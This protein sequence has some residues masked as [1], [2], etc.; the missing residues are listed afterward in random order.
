MTAVASE[1]QLTLSWTSPLDQGTS[2]RSFQTV[3]QKLLNSWTFEPA[4]S[5]VQL[6]SETPSMHLHSHPRAN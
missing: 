3:F 6:I 5:R 2:A 4:A 1:S